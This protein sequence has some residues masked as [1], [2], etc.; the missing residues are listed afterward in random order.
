M[1]FVNN[2]ATSNCELFLNPFSNNMNWEMSVITKTTNERGWKSSGYV[3][4]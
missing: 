3:H 2:F 1:S 4:I